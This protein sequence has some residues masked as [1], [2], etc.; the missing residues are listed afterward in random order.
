[1]S[2]GVCRRLS[3]FLTR[4]VCRLLRRSLHFHMTRL[5]LLLLLLLTTAAFVAA[6]NTTTEAPTTTEVATTTT[7]TTTTTTMSVAANA[8]MATTQ[9]TATTSNS[10]LCYNGVLDAGE[11]CDAPVS[12]GFC[13]FFVFLF[14]FTRNLLASCFVALNVD[15]SQLAACVDLR[16]ATAMSRTFATE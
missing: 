3:L 9:T 1:M 15:W 16:R 5:W 6:Q 11:E 7:T 8:T 12:E 13:C 10:S 2:A 14:F 4:P